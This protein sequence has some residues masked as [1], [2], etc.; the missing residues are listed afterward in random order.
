MEA[1]FYK[2]SH[3][4]TS[5]SDWLSLNF[6]CVPTEAVQQL[7]CGDGDCDPTELL[8][9]VNPTECADCVGEGYVRS[10]EDSEFPDAT[11][12]CAACD[13][14]GHMDHALAGY[15]VGWGTMYQAA[16]H[17]EL[18]DALDKAGFEVYRPVG[19]MPFDG[20][21]FGV[22]GGGY[23]FYTAHWSVLR[24]LLCLAV[25][26]ETKTPAMLQHLEEWCEKHEA[27]GGQTF[28]SRLQSFTNE[29]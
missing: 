24:A 25:P 23:S 21:L 1:G 4:E 17:P 15:P 14:S 6:E 3:I 7:A 2:V 19:G 26:H 28:R 27:S 8:E 5:L 13:G 22:D 20:I 11:Q 9:H 12:A 16:D 10:Y 29:E 18:V